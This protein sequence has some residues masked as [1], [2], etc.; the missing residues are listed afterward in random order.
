MLQD[1]ARVD[2]VW[3]TY[4]ENSLK[5]QRRQDRRRG[6]HN[7]ICVDNTTKIPTNWRNFLPCDANKGNF[8]KLL[9]TAIE[10]FEPQQR[11]KWSVH[12]DQN[13]VSSATTD[14]SGLF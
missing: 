2:V 3:D 8:F 5:T 7:I 6:N 10:E 1:V 13:T 9:A 14:M 12:I 4:K 11:N